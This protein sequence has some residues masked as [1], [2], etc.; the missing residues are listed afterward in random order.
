MV[1]C[2]ADRTDAPLLA[3][4][5]ARFELRPEPADPGMDHF[6]DYILACESLERLEQAIAVDLAGPQFMSGKQL[7]HG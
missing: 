2:G 5:G 1:L 4:F 7:K 6:N 3:S